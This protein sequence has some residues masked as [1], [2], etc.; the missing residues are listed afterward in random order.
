MHH[1]TVQESVTQPDANTVEGVLLPGILIIKGLSLEP[2][3]N[4]QKEHR[5]KLPVTVSKHVL[6]VY[7]EGTG[8]RVLET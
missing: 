2:T 7:L 6:K 5:H 4:T 3:M 1:D 8:R